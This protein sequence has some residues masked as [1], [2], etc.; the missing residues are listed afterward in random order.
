[1][2]GQNYWC[3]RISTDNSKFLFKELIQGR[4]RQGWGYDEG[5]NLRK[6]TVNEGASRNRSMFD[7]VKKGD[8]LLIPK[9]PNWGDVAIVEATENWNIGYKFEIDQTQGD[10]GHIFPAKYLKRFTRDNENVTGNLRS[11]LKNMSRFWNI[12]HYSEDVKKLLNT[13]ETELSKRQDYESRFESSIGSVFNEIFDPKVFEN[14]I[15][16]KLNE[17]F[18]RE[19][20]EHALVHGLKHL[21]PFYQIERRGGPKE[22]NHG[23]D[24]LIKLPGILPDY[25]YAIAIQVKDY[26]GFVGKDVVEQINKA[27]YWNNENLIVID[28]IVIVTK[29]RRDDNLGLLEHDKNIKFIF[30]NELKQ[31]LA[32]IGKI[33]IGFK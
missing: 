3:Y 11:T 23:T 20:W 4:L 6:L 27:D 31:L 26:E 24:I 10:F 18:T 7:K 25:Q 19:E 14:R 29:A 2:K 21:F 16:D 22:I 13:Q 9:F 28:K 15:Y 1:M 5:Q 32:Q 8:I 30:A 12:N 17:Q 33:F